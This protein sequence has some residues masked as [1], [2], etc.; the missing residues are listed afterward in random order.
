MNTH[1]RNAALLVASVGAWIAP[2][3]GAQTWQE[4]GPMPITDSGGYSG[5]V[6]AI[7]C[8][9]TDPN[10]YYIGGADGGVWKTI[11]G[12]TT[13]T[14]VTDHMPTTAIGAIAVDPNNDQVVYVGTGEANYANHSRYGLGIYKATD[15]GATWTQ[16]AENTFG[17][18]TFSKIV[19]DPQNTSVLYAAVAR[20]G[21]FPALA[22]A[23]GHPGAN[24]PVG[25]FKSNDGGVTWT[26]L[27]NG[28]P[29]VEAS[30]VSINRQNPSVVYAAIGNI[31]GNSANGVYKSTDGG[32]SWTKLT[33]G[34]PSSGVGR[35]SLDVAPSSPQT[36]YALFTR[37]CDA[38]GG[39]ASSIGGY[40]SD[41]G[42]AT[43][44]ARGSVDQ[45][46]YGWYLSCVS[47]K[48]D[49]PNTVFYGGFS[50]ARYVGSSGSNVT[51]P[52][53]D[54]HATAWDAAG[55]L[56]NGNDGGIFRSTNLGNSWT[57]LNAKVGTTQL[58]AGLSSHPTDD[59]FF[60]GGFQ[61]NGTNRRST[62]ST[63]WQGVLGGDGGWTQ[64]NQ[65]N[66]SIMFGEYQG[67]GSLYRSTNGGG[68]FNYAGSGIGG[69]NCFLPPYVIDPNNPNT[70]YYGSDRIYRSTNGGTSWGA[71][72]GD[73]TDGA[74]AIRSL[75]IAP[76]NSN[77]L[78]A[79]TNDG[80]VQ[81][82]TNAG[83]S[84][85]LIRDN[86]PGWPRTTREL[87]VDPTDEKTVYL[88]TA[89]FGTTQIERSTDAG[90]HW[91]AL[92]Q[93]LPD[94]PVN[95]VAADPRRPRL[96]IYAGTDAGLLRTVDGGMTW[97]EFP[98]GLPHAPVIDIILDTQR[99]RIVVGTQG[100]GAW[101]APIVYCSG[102]WNGDG[103]TDTLDILAFL[104]DWNAGEPW[105]DINGDGSV[106]TLDVLAFLNDW[107]AGC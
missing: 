71:W 10:L 69:R 98:P 39:G 22:G 18:R 44:Y 57:S 46:S 12:G 8:S 28:I 5:R 78:Y 9:T 13:W 20:A 47:V 104:N 26:H 88:A 64:I 16:L 61:D 102:D 103:K 11:D 4:L 1:A 90:Q 100:R 105:A 74:G 76:S 53:V 66:P 19:I 33:S 56:L 82:S 85:T 51:P 48:P 58:Y 99:E 107:N 59:A 7:G 50:M 91:E 37:Q 72:S 55:R 32:S 73:L 77:Y 62:N 81:V 54:L 60:L 38:S 87:F 45:S 79:A 14:P 15:G 42:G 35:V 41:D 94:I 97:H 84:F 34:L 3:V 2:S 106:N 86:H 83:Q 52:H 43:W 89:Y 31:F 25:V 30:D 96:T 63:S 27:T 80:N 95:V 36:L 75:A 101:M 23:K 6:S 93:H 65:S 67:T 40:R 92:D 70:V 68:S 17:G 29:A 24:G 49:D 21:G